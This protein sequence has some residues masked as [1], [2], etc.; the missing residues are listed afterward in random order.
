MPT[1]FPLNGLNQIVSNGQR[2]PIIHLQGNAPKS[3]A[4]YIQQIHCI[5]FHPTLSN[6]LIE[7][8]KLAVIHKTMFCVLI[9]ALYVNHVTLISDQ[10]VGSCLTALISL[11]YM[12]GQYYA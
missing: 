6:L 12:L 4:V 3:V 2:R 5:I 1:C 10:M 9:M 8:L 7:H 11:P